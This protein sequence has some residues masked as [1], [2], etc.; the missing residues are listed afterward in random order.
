[1]CRYMSQEEVFKILKILGGKA[2]IKD[3]TAY[4][5]DHYP[6]LSLYMYTTKRLKQM[7]RYGF[8]KKTIIGKNT[9]WE[10]LR[11]FK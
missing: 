8:V 1:M 5:R 11:E 7:E 10:I 4:A 2:S 6:N 3:I 9:V